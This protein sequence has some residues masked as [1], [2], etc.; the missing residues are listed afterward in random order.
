ME[1]TYVH[2]SETY[3]FTDVH[4]NF[5]CLYGRCVSKPHCDKWAW[6][7]PNGF[8]FLFEERVK[9]TEIPYTE[10]PTLMIPPNCHYWGGEIR[11]NASHRKPR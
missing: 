7:D 5:G 8:Q 4:T 9:A 11:A 1:K 2:G 6:L 3:H 10:G